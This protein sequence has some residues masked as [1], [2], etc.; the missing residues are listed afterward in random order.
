MHIRK[1]KEYVQEIHLSQWD[2]KLK[3]AVVQF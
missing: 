3:Q 1:L 2:R